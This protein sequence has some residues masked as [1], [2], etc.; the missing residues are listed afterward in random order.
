MGQIDAAMG[1]KGAILGPERWVVWPTVSRKIALELCASP[2][3]SS[4]VAD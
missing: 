4:L 1:K 3:S 2:N